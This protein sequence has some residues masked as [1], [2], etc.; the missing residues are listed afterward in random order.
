MPPRLVRVPPQVRET[1]RS[2]HPALKRDVRA[3]LD[4]VL[5]DPQAGKPLRGALEGLRSYRMGSFRLIYRDAGDCLEIVAL[6]P[7][8]RI[9]QETE[10][11]EARERGRD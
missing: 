1:I 11:L 8:S 4:L 7:R 3:A 10:A 5:A 6:G 9:Y 2:L